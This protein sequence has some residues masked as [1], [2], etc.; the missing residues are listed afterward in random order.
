MV[1]GYDPETKQ[2][3]TEEHKVSVSHQYGKTSH[4][5]NKELALD[6]MD[7]EFV[8]LHQK[9]NID[10]NVSFK[11]TGHEYNRNNE[12]HVNNKTNLYTTTIL[13]HKQL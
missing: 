7:Q 12:C 5:C 9:I 1:Y 13:L 3:S 8:P 10:F 2:Q 6:I 4:R 11:I